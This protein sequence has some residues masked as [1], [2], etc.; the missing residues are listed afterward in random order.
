[1]DT[2]IAIAVR[3][4]ERA[5]LLKRARQLLEADPRVVAAW[6]FGSMG[7]AVE[8]E[9]S[10]IDLFIVVADTAMSS[11]IGGRHYFAQSVGDPLMYIEAPQDAPQGGSYLLMVYPGEYGP[12]ILDC[13]WQPQSMALRP[14]D[15]LLLF[16]RV[17]IPPEEPALEVPAQAR[18]EGAVAQARYF[19][20]MTT[21]V[22]KYIA[23]HD[24]W[25]V[26][27]L[28]ASV[29]HTVA[30]IEWLVGRRSTPPGHRHQPD[31]APPIDLSGQLSMLRALMARMGDLSVTVPALAAAITQQTVEQAYRFC[32]LVESQ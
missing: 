3:L 15:T 17:D 30:E 11:V 1:M 4:S 32:L 27:R 12:L 13:M 21:I 7:R 18:L 28:L 9:W 19:W 25:E 29:S 5:A 23:R 16:D 8:D 10:D 24:S 20:M 6:L 14:V 22:A 31:F 2:P 26:L